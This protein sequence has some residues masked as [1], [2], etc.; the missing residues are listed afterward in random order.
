MLFSAKSLNFVQVAYI[1][2]TD[3]IQLLKK[4]SSD[5][6]MFCWKRDY[7]KYGSHKH[8]INA[9]EVCSNT[10]EFEK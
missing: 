8:K 7:I 5:H 10:H 3:F 1:Q 4:Y 2:K 6:S 9:C